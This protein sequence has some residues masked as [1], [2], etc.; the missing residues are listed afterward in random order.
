MYSYRIADGGMLTQRSPE[1]SAEKYF[2]LKPY[3]GR[4]T[5]L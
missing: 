5:E 2:Y 1:Q 3:S 4:N